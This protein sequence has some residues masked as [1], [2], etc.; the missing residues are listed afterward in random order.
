MEEV[1]VMPEKKEFDAVLAIKLKT[2][3]DILSAN[4]G[5]DDNGMIGLFRPMR[6]K[7]ITSVTERG[8]HVLR[9]P[10]MFA[11]YSTSSTILLDQTD[12]LSISRASGFYTRFYWVTLGN[13]MSHEEHYQKYMTD[14][15]D[16]QDLEKSIDGIDKINIHETVNTTQ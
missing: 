14:V 10:E 15:F 3:E 11:P 1:T 16:E 8:T 12:I 7:T 9:V 4:M 13:L 5:M 6:V 2:G